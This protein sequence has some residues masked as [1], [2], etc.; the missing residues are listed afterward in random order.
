MQDYNNGHLYGLEKFWAFMKYRSDK[1]K[2]ELKP[3]LAKLLEQYKTL[4]D[5]RSAIPTPPSSSSSSA[6]AAAQ[7]K[8]VVA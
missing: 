1:R 7:K 4:E 6:A 2:V 5:F 8:E 3:Q